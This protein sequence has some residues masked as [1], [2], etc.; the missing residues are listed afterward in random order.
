MDQ[1]KIHKRVNSFIAGSA[2]C[3][4]LPNRNPMDSEKRLQVKRHDG[5]HDE[6]H[7]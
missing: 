5:R 6:R 7:A 2:F 3:P 1:A 4:G